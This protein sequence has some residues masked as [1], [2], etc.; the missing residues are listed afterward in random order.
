MGRTKGKTKLNVLSFLVV[1][2]PDKPI[3]KNNKTFESIVNYL[4]S[5]GEFLYLL[6]TVGLSQ[7]IVELLSE[8]EYFKDT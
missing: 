2:C 7:I 1:Y 5:C 6:I 3:E 4:Y 8:I